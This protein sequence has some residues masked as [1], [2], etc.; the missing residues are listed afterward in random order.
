M[1]ESLGTQLEP[2][3][4]LVDG[5]DPNLIMEGDNGSEDWLNSF[6]YDTKGII[7]FGTIPTIV[8]SNMVVTFPFLFMAKLGQP[9]AMNGA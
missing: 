2:I 4:E 5:F 9:M 8:L 1:P 3:K 7:Q 6:D